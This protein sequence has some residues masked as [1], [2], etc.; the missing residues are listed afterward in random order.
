MA[1]LVRAMDQSSN[2][3]GG[4]WYPSLTLLYQPKRKWRY[5]WTKLLEQKVHGFYL[6]LHHTVAQEVTIHFYTTQ[7]SLASKTILSGAIT[8]ENNNYNSLILP[9]GSNYQH[10]NITQG[11]TIMS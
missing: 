5:Y 4:I 11:P 7:T 3:G 2:C 6:M 1:P 10:P 8:E 9:R